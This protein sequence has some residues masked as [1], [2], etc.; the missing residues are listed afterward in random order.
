MSSISLSAGLCLHYTVDGGQD[1]TLSWETSV[2][3]V[4]IS[5]QVNIEMYDCVSL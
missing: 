5:M 3:K 1:L 2:E 4:H